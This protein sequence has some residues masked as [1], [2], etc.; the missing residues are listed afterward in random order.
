[1]MIARIRAAVLG[2]AALA[3]AAA[4]LHAQDDERVPQ[5][6]AAQEFPRWLR[7]VK[8]DGQFDPAAL[9]PTDVNT[10]WA[11]YTPA[12]AVDSKGTVHIVYA[13]LPYIEWITQ[14]QMPPDIYYTHNRWKDRRANSWSPPVNISQS[15]TVCLEPDIAIGPSDSI[16]VVWVE[17]SVQIAYAQASAGGLNFSKTL[18]NMNIHHDPAITVD[19]GGGVHIVAHNIGNAYIDYLGNPFGGMPG[20]VTGS[21]SGE[22]PRIHHDSA[23]NPNVVWIGNLRPMYNVRAGGAWGGGTTLSTN[24]AVDID[25]H[26][27]RDNRAHFAWDTKNLSDV[28]AGTTVKYCRTTSVS[29]ATLPTLSGIESVAT[30]GGRFPRIQVDSRLQPH[31]NWIYEKIQPFPGVSYAAKINRP[32]TA[33]QVWGRQEPTSTITR[34]PYGVINSTIN[35]NDN[36][37]LTFDFPDWTG[38]NNGEDEQKE[39]TGQPPANGVSGPPKD[40]HKPP[41]YYTPPPMN[42]R[43]DSRGAVFSSRVIEFNLGGQDSLGMIGVG[44]NTAANAANGNATHSLPLFATSGHGISA[45]LALIHNSQ[46]FDPGD[47]SQGWSHSYHV[48]ATDHQDGGARSIQ[49]GDGRTFVY[50]PQ[51]GVIAPEKEFG[52]FSRFTTPVIRK[53]KDGTDYTFDAETGKLVE[54]KDTNNNRL[55]LNYIPNLFGE[56]GHLS[57]IDDSPGRP[58]ATFTWSG[59]TL[60]QITDP[61]GKT[62][63]LGYDTNGRL[64]RV[65]FNGPPSAAWNFVYHTVHTQATGE[66]KWL[67]KEI[68]TPRN[69]PTTLTYYQDNRLRDSKDPTLTQ[70]SV[71]THD[72]RKLTY[73]S[74][75]PPSTPWTAAYKDR[76][77]NTTTF[78]IEYRRS[79]VKKATDPLGKV[80]AQEFDAE[81]RNLKKLTD[82]EGN[83]T[84]FKY[85]HEL[86]GSET[87]SYVKDLLGQILEPAANSPPGAA[88]TV[89]TAE[90]TYSNNI[91]RVLTSKDVAGAVLKYHYD[92]QA[93]SY[94]QAPNAN[95]TIGNLLT[96]A[97]P[98]TAG[99]ETLEKWTVDAQGR[100][101]THQSPRNVDLG[102]QTTYTYGDAQT[103][104]VTR[105]QRPDHAA[106]EQYTYTVMGQIFSQVRPMGGITSYTYDGLH[107]V[108]TMTPPVGDE[109]VVWTYAYDA[110][111]NLTSTTGPSTTSQAFDELGRLIRTDLTASAGM[112]PS[113][114]YRYDGEGNQVEYEDPDGKKT[115]SSFDALGRTL[116][117]TAPGGPG[118]NV[119]TTFTYDGNGNVKTKATG[120]STTNYN[121]SGRGLPLKTWNSGFSTESDETVYNE[122]GTVRKAERRA[123]ASATQA[124]S[125]EYDVLGRLTAS[126]VAAN[127]TTGEG[128]RISYT[129]NKN[130][131]LA[132]LADP[133]GRTTSYDHDLADRQVRAR[134]Q[135]NQIVRQTTFN[136]NGLPSVMWAPD[137]STGELQAISRFGYNGRDELIAMTDAQDNT[138][139]MAYNALGLLSRRRQPSFG[140]GQ[141]LETYEYDG[142]GRQT[143]VVHDP[144]TPQQR[145]F[146]QEYD[147]S[148]NRTKIVDAKGNVYRYRYD[149]AGRLIEM[150]YPAVGG[151][152]VE[153]WAYNN[154]GHMAAHT[155]P[156]GKVVTYAYDLYDRVTTETH[157]RAGVT[158]ANIVRAYDVNHRL[159]SVTDTATRLKQTT[160]YDVQG[161]PLDVAVYLEAGTAQEVLWKRTQYRTAG[162]GPGYD[163]AGNLVSMIDAEGNRYEYEYDA[164]SRVTQVRRVPASGPAAVVASFTYYPY[165]MLR[166]RLLQGG[167]T[168]TFRY[169]AIRQLTFSETVKPDGSVVTRVKY[170]YDGSGLRKEE[171]LDHLSTKRTFVYDCL[172]RLT[173]E[174]W[175]GNAVAPPACANPS[176][177]VTP[178]NVSTWSNV[179]NVMPGTPSAVPAFTA[180]YAYDAN[181]NITTKA[182]TSGA[183]VTTTT[184]AYN[185]ADQ[186]ASETTGGATTTYTYDANGN[187]VRQV[188]GSLEKILAYDHEDKL[189]N[190]LERPVGGA[191]TSSWS[192]L[193][194][195]FGRIA[196]T[197]LLS[198]AANEQWSMLEGDETQAEYARTTG[199]TAYQPLRTF[200]RKPG[201]SD[202]PLARIEAGATERTYH[203]VADTVGTLS[204]LV[205][206]AGTVAMRS[207][208]TAYGEPLPGFTPLN[209]IPNDRKFAGEVQ[210][211]ESG[212]IDFPLRSYSPKQARWLQ[213]DPLAA[214]EGYRYCA[215]NP[216]SRVDRRGGVWTLDNFS[217][218]GELFTAMR[219]LEKYYGR[220]LEV[221][222]SGNVT[223]GASSGKSFNYG[224]DTEWW[225]NQA[226]AT[227]EASIQ[228]MWT[229]MWSHKNPYQFG[230][231]KEA[232]WHY[233]NLANP[234]DILIQTGLEVASA[235]LDNVPIVSTVKSAIEAATGKDLITGAETS[236]VMATIGLIPFAK[237]FKGAKQALKAGARQMD[238]IGEA[239]GNLAKHT[240]PPC[241]GIPKCFAAGT[242]VAVRGGTKPIEEIQLGDEV[243]TRDERTGELSYQPVTQVY[244]ST[245][246]ALVAVTYEELPSDGGLLPRPPTRGAPRSAEQTLLTTDEHPFWVWEAGDWRRAADLRPG[247]TLVTPAG[248][249]RVLRVERVEGQVQVYNFEVR[250]TH[251]Y[252]V[253]A[254]SAG[255]SVWVHNNCNPPNPPTPKPPGPSES[256]KV[257]NLPEV[258]HPRPIKPEEAVKKWD[259]FLGPNTTNKHPRTGKADPDR[260]VS[261]DGTRSIR[262]GNHE[263]TSRKHHYHEERWSYDSA[264]D[265]MTVQNTSYFV[266]PPK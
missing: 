23:G 259:D 100:P 30:Q 8:V 5:K 57:S 220:N 81:Y 184:Y 176:V 38:A 144:G 89:V 167:L 191:A 51:G 52:E 87:P 185:T 62:Y 183:T 16:H 70:A 104:L 4:A 107:R 266:T 256:T 12:I 188:T 168:Q 63:A 203:C 264:T 50:M 228:G 243:L 95:I 17:G 153:T 182:F 205:D 86:G 21:N 260:I 174:T 61:A 177:T 222:P 171:E 155:D 133:S 127:L 151:E 211:A 10:I 200:A 166:S 192:Y 180:D 262:Y 55:T 15:Q 162:G 6:D 138:I 163:A 19:N 254:L 49:F 236:R 221:G 98:P 229:Y 114:R 96:V 37:Y 41:T 241:N 94:A 214:L 40:P 142:L 113:Y 158:L 108:Q 165:G 261:A 115:T 178:G 194:T 190:Y 195:P 149:D 224:S 92:A 129:L 39:E 45:S 204:E 147:L 181:N 124:V 197:N 187:Q 227:H 84:E 209:T 252:F 28:V 240:P 173:R 140:G 31:I 199:S 169:N 14:P 102:G 225:N 18:T 90:Y 146:R 156:S 206:T 179:V 202:G 121:Y 101:L 198:T 76:R 219:D 126:T 258:K 172:N 48:T 79:R 36:V 22:K 242:L 111:S 59:D 213:R 135:A 11:A 43:L 42:R 105:L 118:P 44:P 54:I 244:T 238:N 83:V 46:E 186:L 26:V 128:S 123:G 91:F 223:M 85:R 99:G 232:Y 139:T 207:L 208:L 1:M 66:R 217:N 245:V 88:A 218:P 164:N 237:L 130:G 246:D 239:A 230:R 247:D 75:N 9:V 67:I 253:R 189:R 93:G 265:T 47:L 64:N 78:E 32:D 125:Y 24:S 136:D 3:V 71:G 215:G 25:V 255:P 193:R 103:G 263:M 231:M 143:A 160:T 250:P 148:G 201:S 53:T 116:T 29:P 154:R 175:T 119:A 109:P 97:Y 33:T 65:T 212:L 82:P 210:D 74:S 150:R 27:A 137:P 249:A 73:V 216:V 226:G 233:S 60:T 159:A 132:K 120:G 106:A 152:S 56:K 72:P 141:C 161:R 112:L 58:P 122:S 235:I 2:W 117:F 35:Q 110:D 170:V 248:H 131:A 134:D 34:K 69:N 80:V 7:Q 145:S 196:K 13:G 257:I 20:M 251:T 77:A 157:V 68:R 234:W